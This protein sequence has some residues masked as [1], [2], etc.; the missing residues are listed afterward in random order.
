[1]LTQGIEVS[2]APILVEDI[3]P[4]A[5]IILPT[6]VIDTVLL[7]HTVGVVHMNAGNLFLLRFE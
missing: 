2:I 7:I 5:V 3:I 4:V 6:V 1:M